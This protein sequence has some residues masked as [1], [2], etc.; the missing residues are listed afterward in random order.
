MLFSILERFTIVSRVGLSHF[1]VYKWRNNKDAQSISEHPYFRCLETHL[2]CE[3]RI[4]SSRQKLK[5]K[6]VKSVG[7]ERLEVEDTGS[8]YAEVLSILSSN[9]NCGCLQPT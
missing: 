9:R 7:A 4:S 6:N 3:I 2:I 8:E 5:K 1:C